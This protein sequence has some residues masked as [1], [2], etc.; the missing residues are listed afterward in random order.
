M[1]FCL[2]LL[3]VLASRPVRICFSKPRLIS[4]FFR[5]S[6]PAPLALPSAY[7]NLVKFPF[8]PF[9]RHA[10]TDFSAFKASPLFGKESSLFIPSLSE[11]FR[12]IPATLSSSSLLTV[13]H[14]C[15]GAY[16]FFCESQTIF[17]CLFLF[18]TF[19]IAQIFHLSI[20]FLKIFQKNLKSRENLPDF[21]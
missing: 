11:I 20:G 12:C 5:S 21:I 16:S 18:C 2:E 10:S 15:I 1:L 9:F 17:V 19:I 3:F 8:A 14:A 6:V 4:P 7:R 13:R